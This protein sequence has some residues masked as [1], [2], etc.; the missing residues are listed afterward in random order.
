MPQTFSYQPRQNE[1]GD[2]PKPFIHSNP[3]AKT[4]RLTHKRDNTNPPQ[5][6]AMSPTTLAQ[7]FFSPKTSGIG[8][9]LNDESSRFGLP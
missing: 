8:H 6:T 5:D 9:V 4:W 3:T 2:T 7:A 1:P